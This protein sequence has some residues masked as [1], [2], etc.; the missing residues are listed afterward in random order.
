MNGW[1]ALTAISFFA[2]IGFV[3]YI[4]TKHQKNDSEEGEDK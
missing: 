2:L 3:V 4:M 1:E